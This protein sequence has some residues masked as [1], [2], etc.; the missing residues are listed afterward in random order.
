MNFKQAVCMAA[1]SVLALP[2]LAAP[3]EESDRQVCSEQVLALAESFLQDGGKRQD[4]EDSQPAI[5]SAC[6][7]WPGKEPYALGAFIYEGLE[8]NTK[9]MLVAL[10]D[11][12]PGKVIASYWSVVP[13]DA[14]L[15]YT[16]GIRIDTARYQ[17]KPDL[18]AFGVDINSYAPRYDYGGN[19]YLRTLFVR[20]GTTIRPVLTNMAMSRWYYM[21]D[22]WEKTGDEDG[23][24][25]EVQKYDYTIR[26]AA[27][28][29]KGFAD[30]LIAR[31]SNTFEAKPQSRLLHY[32]GRSYPTPP[33][34]F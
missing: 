16:D 31:K 32:D 17:L 11:P 29:S 18:R 2:A 15:R 3:Q 9:R 19:G 20:E 21:N 25:P 6:K 4:S 10:L 33:D 13:S 7:A 1:V 5:A 8:A 23:P 27:T 34:D 14:V 22:P 24:D 30:L 26:I 12:G 28:R